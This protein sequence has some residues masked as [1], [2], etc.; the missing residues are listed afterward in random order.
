MY[1][2]LNYVFENGY[3]LRIIDG[4]KKYIDKHGHLPEILSAEI[5]ESQGYP[6]RGDKYAFAGEDRRVKSVYNKS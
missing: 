5:M 6:S 3:K 1:W 2:Q 4:L